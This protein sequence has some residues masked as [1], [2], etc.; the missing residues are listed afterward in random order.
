MTS[1]GARAW[2]PT[3]PWRVVPALGI[4]QILAW[5]S[6]YYLPAVL[7]Q[8]IA[9]DTGWALSWVVGG[10]SLGLLVAGLASPLVGRRI[11]RHG[12]RPILAMS[13]LLL[14]G[15]LAGLALA[16]NL[17]AFIAAW[18]VMGLGMGAGLYDPAF[19]TLG[20]LYGHG[21]RQHITTLTLFGGFASTA[22]W[23]LSALL[24]SELGWRG[25]CF[26]YAV[27]HLL[28][29]LPLY[30]KGLP[31]APAEPV[32]DPVAPESRPGITP[33]TGRLFILLAATLMIGAVL[34]TL[35]SVHLLT[36]LQAR[37]ISLAAAVALGALVGPS[38]VSARFIEMLVGRYHHPIWTK[39]A[40]VS[41][42]ALGLGLLWFEIPLIACAMI[43]YGAGI[44]LESIARATL[45]LTLF[46]PDD[47]A[48]IMGRLARPSLIAQAAAPALGALLIQFMGPVGGLGI[49]VL[50]ACGNVVLVGF[51]YAA[52]QKARS[53]G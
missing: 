16:P 30:W 33:A 11:R 38:Q 15:G 50:L 24:V 25:A 34:S 7:A 13:S 41:F 26:S 44:G 45:P 22:C 53:A 40:S 9:L 5:G 52:C 31:T 28:V 10:L 20:H 36:I 42:V 8:P 17:P 48:P 47:Y 18:V 35:M 46:G 27:L 3:S 2:H 49:V 4:A 14:S 29:C 1:T 37:D 6:S 32:P 19:S 51:L 23:P 21:A 39:I 43:F 12:G